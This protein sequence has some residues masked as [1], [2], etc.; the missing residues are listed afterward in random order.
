MLLKYFDQ[1]EKNQ[2]Q[3]KPVLRDKVKFQHLNLLQP[4]SQLGRMDVIMCR[5]VLIYF[6][7]H[8]KSGVLDRMASLVQNPGFLFLGSAETIMGLCDRFQSHSPEAR[9]VFIPK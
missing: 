6:D 4:F 7:D 5:N 8:T 2:W 3:A 9:G 1:L